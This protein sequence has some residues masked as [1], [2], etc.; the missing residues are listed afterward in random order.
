MQ[1]HPIP[2]NITAFEFKLVG[3][4]TL[5]QFGYLGIAGVICFILFVSGGGI[6]KWFFIVPIASL[7]LAFA[8][9]PVGGVPFDKWIVL[10]INTLRNPS[11]RVWR[12][13]PKQISFLAPQFSRYLRRPTEK[14]LVTHTRADLE[15][16]L[17]Q[18]RAERKT[19]KL[20]NLEKTRMNMLDFGLQEKFSVLRA[21][22][23]PVAPT[24]PTQAVSAVPPVTPAEGAAP[25]PL[26]K[27]TAPPQ[28]QV[29][30]I[31][32]VKQSYSGLAG[33]APSISGQDGP[34]KGGV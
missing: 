7:A 21:A 32:Q 10:F 6:I 26:T 24:F 8:F 31:E 34:R 15:V 13:E 11:K 27:I 12:K 22:R 14:P 29:P 3:F 5:K 16:F 30:N 33:P 9:L 20:D 19:N 23:P 18:L 1:Q 28:Q 2:Q 17:T 4:L 25:Q